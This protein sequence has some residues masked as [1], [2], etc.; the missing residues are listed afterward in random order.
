MCRITAVATDNFQ[1]TTTSVAVNITVINVTGILTE[2]NRHEVNIYPVP[3]KNLLTIEFGSKPIEAVNIY[4]FDIS[5][6]ILYS[7]KAN[8]ISQTLDISGF[9]DGFYLVKISGK[10][11]NMIQ[12]I[13][14]Q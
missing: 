5:G 8:D 7:T 12:K 14:K 2:N 9:S 11:M 6:R 10:N 3:A 13:I 4:L 1:A